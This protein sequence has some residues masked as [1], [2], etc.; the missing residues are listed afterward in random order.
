MTTAR[1]RRLTILPFVVLLLAL[2]WPALR[3]PQVDAATDQEYIAL[4]DSIAA[5]LITSLPSERGF[6]ALVTAQMQKLATTQAPPGRVKL[7]NL[8]V[9][10]ETAATFVTNGQLDA[11]KNEIASVT[12]QGTDLKLV[13]ITLGGNE[14]LNLAK[15]GTDQRQTGLDSFKTDYPAAINDIVQALGGLK[16][17]IV[18]T[19]YYDLSDSDPAQQGSDAWWVAQFN[20][21][22]RSTAQANGFKVAD[23]EP[24]FRGHIADWTWNPTDVHPNNAGHAEIARLI[25][26]AAGFDQDPPVVTIVKPAAGPLPRAIPTIAVTATDNVGVTSV[27]LWVNDTKISSLIYEPSLQQYVGVWDSG[28]ASSDQTTLSIRAT[29][30]A[31]HTTTATVDVTKPSS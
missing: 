9:P 2:G 12:A 7:T 15:T 28:S 29:D 21:V 20:D 23:L 11:F 16:P 22:I 17:V 5:G 24:D 4:G 31:G 14:L 26:T 18:V 8:A 1:V 27:E 30:L 10:G 25:W 19:T 13:T 3:A 6:P